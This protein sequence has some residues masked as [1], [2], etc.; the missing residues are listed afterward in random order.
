M[1]SSIP[2]KRLGNSE[3]VA[4]LV[5]YLIDDKSE[6]INGTTTLQSRVEDKKNINSWSVWI[7]RK[8]FIKF[9]LKNIEFME[10]T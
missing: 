9:F 4:N 2:N 6:Y 1:L 7:Y 8:K 10:L 5:N 3:E